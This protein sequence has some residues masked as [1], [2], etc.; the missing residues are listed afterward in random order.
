MTVELS[1]FTS[2]TEKAFTELANAIR[3]LGLPAGYPDL[4]EELRLLE[5]AFNRWIVQESETR[6]DVKPIV[7]NSLFIW[8]LKP[9][10]LE[11]EGIKQEILLKMGAV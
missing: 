8:N 3:T 10:I 11:L 1:R 6:K 7:Q 2:Q 4:A 5:L 9:L